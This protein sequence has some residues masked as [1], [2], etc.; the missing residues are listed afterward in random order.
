MTRN[1]VSKKLNDPTIKQIRLY[2]FRHYFGTKTF[3]KTQSVGITAK[4]LGHKNWKNTQIYVD[5][6]AILDSIEEDYVTAT[7]ETVK[8]ACK[9]IEQGFTHVLDMQGIAI[10]KKRK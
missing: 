2:D 8:E 4:A 7:A 1:K 10:F 9:L 3:Q 6:Q 5:I